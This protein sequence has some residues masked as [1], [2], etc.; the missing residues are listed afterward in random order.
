MNIFLTGASG[1]I[2]QHLLQALITNQHQVSICCR[3]A[4]KI[5]FQHPQLTIIQLDFSTVCDK[6]WLPHLQNVDVVIN[7]VGIIQ[8]TQQARFVQIHHHATCALFK[9][10]ERAGIKKIIQI[11]AL[12]AE[13]NANTEYFTSK[14]QA[15][16]FLKTLAVDWLIFKPSIVYGQ[17]A[18]S[19]A[20][21][22]ALSALPITP[23]IENG[24]Q[25]IQPVFIDDLV[26]AILLAL[27]PHCPTQRTILAVGEKPIKIRDLHAQLASWLGQSFHPI[28]MPARYIENLAPLGAFFGEAALNKEAIKMLQQG[29]TAASAAFTAFLGYRPHDISETLQITCASQAERWQARLYFLRPMLRVSIA[30]VWLWAGIVSAFLYPVADNYVMLQRVGINGL[31]A[32]LTLYSASLADFCLGLATLFCWRLRLTVWLQ[33]AIMLIYSTIITIYLPEAWLHPF[34][35]LIKNLP[36]ICATFVLLTLEEEQP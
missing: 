14:A 20:L 3:N 23:L 5:N 34:G 24:N 29:N 21:L 36:L 28:A 35:A 26:Q 25:V 1:F 32:S 4:Q 7:A 27:N 31:L 16:E 18:K 2:G 12:G 13:L 9:A 22:T 30:L 15:D 10:C 8:Q 17:G 19:L 33:M 6:D 11:S